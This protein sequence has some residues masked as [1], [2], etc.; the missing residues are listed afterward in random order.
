MA[1]SMSANE[2]AAVGYRLGQHVAMLKATVEIGREKRAAGQSLTNTL[3]M[4][5]DLLGKIVEEL[6]LLQPPRPPWR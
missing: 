6:T 3:E 1:D 5:E 2:A 4:G